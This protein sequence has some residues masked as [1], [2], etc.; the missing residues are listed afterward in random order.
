MATE[1]SETIESFWNS[2]L[3]M[4]NFLMLLKLWL[5]CCYSKWLDC[6]RFWRA[7]KNDRWI[8]VLG[9]RR[10]HWEIIAS[11]YVLEKWVMGSGMW[12]GVGSSISLDWLAWWGRQNEVCSFSLPYR[13]VQ[14]TGVIWIGQARYKFADLGMKIRHYWYI[15][16]C[17]PVRDLRLEI[18]INIF[19]FSITSEISPLQ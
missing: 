8:S 4:P 5:N 15:L 11:I 1:C 10:S 7:S 12:Q 14:C 13:Q 17:D 16:G 2:C 6:M 9:T 3:L 19:Y 18:D